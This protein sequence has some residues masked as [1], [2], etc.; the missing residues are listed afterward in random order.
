MKLG[1]NLVQPQFR[2]G[3]M[4]PGRANLTVAALPTLEE[5]LPGGQTPGL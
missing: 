4:A 1:S 3:V 5:Q 2:P